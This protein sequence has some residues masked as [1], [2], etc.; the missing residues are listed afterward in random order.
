M[1]EGS[2][3]KIKTVTAI[4]EARL[5]AS[6]AATNLSSLTNRPTPAAAEAVDALVVV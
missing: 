2:T 3:R 5:A 4:H 1:P 6:K